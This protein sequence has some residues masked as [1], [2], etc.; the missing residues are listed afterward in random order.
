MKTGL[1]CFDIGNTAIDVGVFEND[2]LIVRWKHPTEKAWGRDNYARLLEQSLTERG[3]AVSAI[4]RAALSSVV[5]GFQELF[6]E[7]VG[8]LFQTQPLIVTTYLDLGIR[9]TWERPWTVG[10]DRLLSTGEAYRLYGGPVIVAGV[11]TAITVDVVSADG[12]FLGG[13]IAPGLRTGLDALVLKTSL[14]PNVPLE[15]PSRVIGTDTPSFLLSGVVVGAA[16]L[17]DGLVKQMTKEVGA[18]VK[19]VGTGGDVERVRPWSETIEIIDHDLSLKGLRW[20]YERNR[21]YKV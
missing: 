4:R 18:E 15:D 9:V 3:I 7:V 13:A 2:R 5:R 21:E 6:Q 8:T 20:V 14:L 12:V 1:I 19:V 17:I 11:G 10:I 16:G